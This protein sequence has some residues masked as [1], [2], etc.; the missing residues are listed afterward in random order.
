MFLFHEL[1]IKSKSFCNAAHISGEY[2]KYR[3]TKICMLNL[4]PNKF[5]VC[6]AQTVIK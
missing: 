1:S 3:K 4:L 6:H 5:Y 2:L